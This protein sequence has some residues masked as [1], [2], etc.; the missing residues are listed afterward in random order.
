MLT[1]EEKNKKHGKC[2]NF[3]THEVCIKSDDS[4][5]TD[6]WVHVAAVYDGQ[7]ATLYVDAEKQRDKK[8]ISGNVKKSCAHL[9]LGGIGFTGM[10][11]EARISNT[12]RINFG[13][14]IRETVLR[15]FFYSGWSCI[16]E[17]EKTAP[18]GGSFGAE[19]VTRQFVEGANI[20]EHICVDYYGDYGSAIERTL[21][22]HQN[23][24]GDVVALT[25]AGGEIFVELRYSGYGEVFKV[26]ENQQLQPLE[27]NERTVFT[28]Q[29]RRIDLESGHLMY[30]RNRYYSSHTGRFMSRDRMGY[31]DSYSLYQ[32]GNMSPLNYTDPL[33][34]KIF[35]HNN[36]FMEIKSGMERSSGLISLLDALE[37]ST[38]LALTI[39]PDRSLSI[40]TSRRGSGQGSEFYRSYLSKLINQSNDII[41]G[42]STGC[43]AVISNLQ[44]AKELLQ[45]DPS[46]LS[47]VKEEGDMWTN[48]I[49]W[50]PAF[51]SN[52]A[53]YASEAMSFAH[54][55]WHV[56]AHVSDNINLNRYPGS[57]LY[58]LGEH[59]IEPVDFVN[60]IRKDLQG[61][62]AKL[63]MTY[64]PEAYVDIYGKLYNIS[65]NEIDIESLGHRNPLTLSE[66]MLSG[67]IWSEGDARKNPVSN[68]RTYTAFLKQ[69]KNKYLST[70]FATNYSK[71]EFN[72]L[73]LNVNF[74]E[75]K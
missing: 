36:F 14:T 73:N 43:V 18:E 15:Q 71:I 20:D 5:P 32:F 37:E 4:L 28:F 3:K 55:T 23:A 22:Y 54:E 67:Y 41:F 24:R 48:V 70:S 33:G 69:L 12:A 35:F 66:T 42:L 21:W 34:D 49:E 68:Y 53:E 65:V 64:S 8:P 29:G 17:R 62:S 47:K 72:L 57:N 61:E 30:F 74:Q 9:F 51:F 50:N 45:D 58:Y 75:I 25:D 19:K 7:K 26:G 56:Y 10:M 39:C 38:G 46:M 63:Q 31:V 16:E 60:I 44:E 6:Q 13:G 59:N 40:D 1:K 52:R 11:E 2:G 27:N